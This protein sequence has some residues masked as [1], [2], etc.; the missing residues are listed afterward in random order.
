MDLESFKQANILLE[1]LAELSPDSV[2][3]QGAVE[4][5]DQ[6]YFYFDSPDKILQFVQAITDLGLTI[7]GDGSISEESYTLTVNLGN[8][9][10]YLPRDKKQITV[11]S[12]N[13]RA[14]FSTQVVAYRYVCNWLVENF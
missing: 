11:V 8:I 9:T 7:Q 13:N 6:T 2:W 12:G 4:G 3:I 1:Q 14:T 5:T 10:L